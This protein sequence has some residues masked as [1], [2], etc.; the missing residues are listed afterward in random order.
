MNSPRLLKA[1][2]EAYTVNK[3][4]DADDRAYNEHVLQIEGR[5]YR[6]KT[7]TNLRLKSRVGIV[8]S[9]DES[10]NIL[11]AILPSLGIEW[12]LGL[13][14]L[15]T[16]VSRTDRFDYVRGR[17]LRRERQSDTAS[18]DW[19]YTVKMERDDFYLPRQ[20][21]DAIR[22]D[23]DI[24]VAFQ[25]GQYIYIYN[26]TRKLELG[27]VL[28]FFWLLLVLGAGAGAYL[29]Y[30]WQMGQIEPI[31]FYAS[32]GFVAFCVLFF[33]GINYL[34]YRTFGI[35]REGAQKMREIGA[36]TEFATD[37]KAQIKP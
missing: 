6:A 30:M 32:L 12:G 24:V 16:L 36:A 26:E 4:Y 19:S 21:A 18:G 10:G 1:S 5:D 20:Y 9:V 25:N 7:P 23:D 28:P 14:V 8:A 17:V 35:A 33:G 34:G 3:K 15:R 22:E 2:I 13:K 31:V 11:G 29:A 27:R 37:S